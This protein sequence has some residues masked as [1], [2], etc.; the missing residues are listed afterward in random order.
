MQSRCVAGKAVIFDAETAGAHRAEGGGECVERRHAKGDQQNDFQNRHGQINAI[1]NL[2]GVLYMRHKLGDGGAGA[3][4]AHQV[5]VGT[6]HHGQDGHDK[7]KYAHT[8]NPVCK[9]APEQAGVCQRFHF[10]QDT[11]PGGGKAGDCLEQRI[12]IGR[13]VP[14]QHE[15]QRPENTHHKPAER[16]GGEPLPG[17]DRSV[18]GLAD[19]KEQAAGQTERC[20]KEIR[21]S[22]VFRV[23][24]EI[25]QCRKQQKNALKF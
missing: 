8:A 15:G 24:E 4:G 12:H 7:D 3:L 23:K 10:R 11:G 20:A 1:Q 21:E 5:H 18:F 17:I 19:A 25:Y 16:H 22:G 6:A 13:D 9:A 2:C 14:C